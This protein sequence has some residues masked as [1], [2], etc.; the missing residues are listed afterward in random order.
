MAPMNPIEAAQGQVRSR[1]PAADS[2][3]IAEQHHDERT[4][5]GGEILGFAYGL[6]LLLSALCFFRLR[7][8]GNQS[9][10]DQ[11]SVDFVT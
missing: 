5:L 10:Q 11:T 2:L 1:E 4:A 8:I 3:Q 9:L 7:M 6:Q